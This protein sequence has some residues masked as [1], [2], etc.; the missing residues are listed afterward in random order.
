MLFSICYLPTLASVPII[1]FTMPYRPLLLQ[2]YHCS[3]VF[4][5]LP[6]DLCQTFRLL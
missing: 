1:Q 3:R 2:G 4:S 6:R 5:L